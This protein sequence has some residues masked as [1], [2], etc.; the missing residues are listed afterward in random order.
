MVRG[1]KF[2]TKS[3]PTFETLSVM[4]GFFYVQE[5]LSSGFRKILFRIVIQGVGLVI[6]AKQYETYLHGDYPQEILSQK[7]NK[8]R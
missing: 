1:T 5:I 2:N 8:K 4:V 3:S 6:H 7:I